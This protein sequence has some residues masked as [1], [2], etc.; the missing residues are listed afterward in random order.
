MTETL[1]AAFMEAA[2]L[3]ADRQDKL[4]EWVRDFVEQERSTLSLSDEQRD[5]VRRRLSASDPAFADD[6]EVDAL[7]AKFV[8]R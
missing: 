2:T 4:G 7:F 5:E 1:E 3:P 8:S 6:A